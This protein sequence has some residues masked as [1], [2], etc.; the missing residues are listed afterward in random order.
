M[1]VLD[2][3][4]SAVVATVLELGD[5]G[6]ALAGKDPI[7]DSGRI[8][9]SG[10]SLGDLIENTRNNIGVGDVLEANTITTGLP[11]NVKRALG[12]VG[13]VVLDPLTYVTGGASVAAKTGRGGKAAVLGRDALAT[14]ILNLSDEALAASGAS[15]ELADDAVRAIAGQSRSV[16]ALGA[17]RFDPIREALG[18]DVRVG[19]VFDFGRLG[20]R[21]VA[22]RAAAA[23][24]EAGTAAKQ[25]L[26]TKPISWYTRH[27][28][29]RA[30]LDDL[31]ARWEE[32][33]GL[34]ALRRKDPLKA[35][36]LKNEVTGLKVDV[37]N[38][39]AQWARS[40]EEVKERL[41]DFDPHDLRNAIENPHLFD[42]EQ[43]PELMAA[44]NTMRAFQ[45]Q[46]LQTVE[47]YI[48]REIPRLT[49]YLPH[50]VTLDFLRLSGGDEA[51]ADLLKKRG[52][53]ADNING[54]YDPDLDPK[55]IEAIH[56]AAEEAFGSDF[57]K[58][59]EDDPWQIWPKYIES[60]AGLMAR[61]GVYGR[62]ERA[63]LASLN[64]T[65]DIE[66]MLAGL[67]TN[68]RAAE[69][70]A[71]K[72]E[73]AAARDASKGATAASKALDA[74]QRARV[75]GNDLKPLRR[76]ADALMAEL[77]T[78]TR[79][80]MRQGDVTLEEAQSAA[81]RKVNQSNRQVIETLTK[82]I[83][84]IESQ[85]ESLLPEQQALQQT[86]ETAD[87]LT[88]QVGE[89]LGVHTSNEERLAE[90]TEGIE[91]MAEQVGELRLLRER[92]EQDSGDIITE[93]EDAVEVALDR[94]LESKVKSIRGEIVGGDSGNNHQRNMAALT[95]AVR[96]AVKAGADPQRILRAAAEK[97][98]LGVDE[99]MTDLLT[100]AARRGDAE[101]A[102]TLGAIAN[103]EEVLRRRVLK[104]A[105]GAG[106]WT[107]PT[108]QDELVSRLA[109]A[110]GATEDPIEQAAVRA[111]L[112]HAQGQ[113]RFAQ[114]GETVR[115]LRQANDDPRAVAAVAEIEDIMHRSIE[116]AKK[117]G[118]LN[119]QKRLMRAFFGENEMG[120]A[121]GALARALEVAR[122]VSR[123]VIEEGGDEV[124][125]QVARAA[126]G[127]TDD[128]IQRFER[129]LLT[130]TE[131]KE[132][133][134]EATIKSSADYG[135]AK[136]KAEWYEIM[137]GAAARTQLDEVSNVVSNAVKKQER[138]IAKKAEA[139]AI[140]DDRAS[141]WPSI[142]LTPEKITEESEA[143]MG[144]L[145]EARTL[146]RK[147]P[148]DDEHREV[149]MRINALEA[150]LADAG[151]PIIREMIRAEQGADL[152]RVKAERLWGEKS[153]W[154]AK[155]RGRREMAARHW[156]TAANIGINE[157]NV[158][159]YLNAWRHQMSE[160]TR[161][162]GLWA[163]PDIV[164]MVA[165]S[166]RIA[167]PKRAW[168]LLRLHDEVMA[169]WKAYSLMSPGYHSRN[170][171]S[172]VWMNGLAG[173]SN[174]PAA[175]FR[176][177]NYWRTYLK[178]GREA[179]LAKI[180][181]PEYRRVFAE[182]ID[183]EGFLFG[184]TN[185]RDFVDTIT[186]ASDRGLLG[187]QAGS[188]RRRLDP[189][190][191]EFAAID[192]NFGVA[193]HVES[194]LRGPLYIDSR[195][196]GLNVDESLGQVVKYHF[197][198][199]S[200]SAN[201]RKYMKRIVPFY[202]WTRKN[203]PL[204]LEMIAKRPGY[205]AAY[206]KAQENLE[207]GTPVDEITPSY[208]GP[209]AIRSP[210]TA[211]EMPGGGEEGKRI[212][213]M[214]DLPFTSLDDL[215]DVGKLRSQLSPIIKTPWELDRGQQFFSGAPFTGKW[216]KAPTT[217]LPLMPVLDA[218]NGKFGLPKAVR[219][220]GDYY[221]D[222]RDAYK[223][224]QSLPLLG[225]LRRLFPSEEKYQSRAFSSYL[226]I[227]GGLSSQTNTT[228][229]QESEI[230]RRVRIIESRLKR[231]KQLAEAV[232]PTEDA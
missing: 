16:G 8:K 57:V 139:M 180:K 147:G 26:I 154:D 65:T 219:V 128:L 45:E 178:Q 140:V 187:G 25:A 75:L 223:I 153:A 216:T 108:E 230:L 61:E 112:A 3:S 46:M 6:R 127:M 114:I 149:L 87:D 200:L 30:N 138:W 59:F 93:A 205:Y 135:R 150:E 95:K 53:N 64:K 121:Q 182:V 40:L 221:L 98:D 155:A 67:G 74:S 82:R 129:M 37:A 100:G 179:A 137:H 212:Y 225:R 198:Y 43:V 188:R 194:L 34:R 19:M 192:R 31:V 4:K 99:W 55:S 143:I 81:I 191:L 70:A 90:L 1:D 136:V 63:G 229:A 39:R 77:E 120:Q 54:L 186:G 177:G 5:A 169:R 15:R 206:G 38:F 60:L 224:E 12:F 58:I 106:Q 199:S 17:R 69:R 115:I 201:E 208:Y 232:A 13:D 176:F 185:V 196:K 118:G 44:A 76:E 209:F 165:A 145:D 88:R 68:K 32:I 227:I 113:Q 163:H 20:G 130:N 152:A 111:Q 171:F 84:S 66:K 217:F 164:E 142:G 195:L 211:D 172:G 97:I 123:P 160:F 175:Y 27:G 146:N 56:E 203:L 162:E 116:A 158:Q 174:D 24:S 133:A 83:D 170:F 125:E 103:A 11:L 73:R 10:F 80:I 141:G 14:R 110:L 228:Q 18:P 79:Q 2:T 101:A 85:I 159:E 91:D 41:G 126:A 7:G 193:S 184:R 161:R 51:F 104:V 151:D 148:L 35:V 134:Y 214:P 124:Q 102:E 50:Q 48:G 119:A 109:Q 86:V 29:R 122:D 132:A 89:A 62:L 36:Q 21:T 166:S 189:T 42:P 231:N 204:Q 78:V 49:N 144:L 218:L 215:F 107:P 157:R 33:P 28:G 210:W 202:T 213:W 173:M 226:S 71:R 183:N 190:S 72:A 9:D 181:D 117:G 92:F 197:D 167:E 168:G 207:I 131:L 222:D 94:Y 23:L 96:K 156:D 220:D 105:D 47:R 52:L 22:P